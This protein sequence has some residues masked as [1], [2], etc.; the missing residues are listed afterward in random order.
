MARTASASLAA[1]ALGTLLLAS[2]CGGSSDSDAKPAADGAAKPGA[3]VGIPLLSFDPATVTIKAGQ[4]V[5]WTNG[6]NISHV[7]EEG[8]YAVDKDGLRTSEKS[9]GAFSLKVAKKG[10]V[11]SHTYDK[12][13]TFTYFCTI[14]KGM[15]AT[16]VVQ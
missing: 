10:D 7:L 4:T 1:A 13:G 11:V 2:A 3:S 15:N 12:A 16:V 9:D 8:S 5:T 14:H 6:N